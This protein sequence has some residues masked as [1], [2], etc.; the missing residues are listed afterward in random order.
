M[1]QFLCIIN[2]IVAYYDFVLFVISTIC[3][4]HDVDKM[5][6]NATMA[7]ASTIVSDAMAE[8]TVPIVRTNAI[9]LVFNY[10]LI[11]SSPLSFAYFSPLFLIF[12]PTRI[13]VTIKIN[14]QTL[15]IRLFACPSIL[16]DIENANIFFLVT[17]CTSDEFR[18]QDGTCLGI[19]KRCDGHNDCRNGEDEIQCGKFKNLS[20]IHKNDNSL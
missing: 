8:V 9:A 19:E 11:I 7:T 14:L 2:F 20:T 13:P 6:S 10:L 12:F 4:Q 18:C 5:N 3:T 15:L 16:F 1:H 17:T